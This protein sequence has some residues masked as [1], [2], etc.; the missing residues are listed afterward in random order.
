VTAGGNRRQQ[1]GNTNYSNI[2]NT[3]A[4]IVVG[5][6]NGNTDLGALQWAGGRFPIREPVFL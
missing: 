3:R 4:S 1:G 6:I 5:A 2:S